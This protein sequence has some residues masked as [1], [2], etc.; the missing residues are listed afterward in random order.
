MVLII[1]RVLTVFTISSFEFYQVRL[2]WLS[3]QWWMASNSSDFNPLDYQ[4]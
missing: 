3:H 2:P 1:P 4:V